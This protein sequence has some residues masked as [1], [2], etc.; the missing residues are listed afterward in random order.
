MGTSS[1][2]YDKFTYILYTDYIYLHVKG[3]PLLNPN[4]DIFLV[5]FIV[6]VNVS[7]EDSR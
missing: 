5:V 2:H 4:L 1:F 7:S 3:E 6:S